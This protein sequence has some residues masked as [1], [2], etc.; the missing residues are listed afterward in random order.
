ME[1]GVDGTTAAAHAG[2]SIARVI[3]TAGGLNKVMDDATAGYSDRYPFRILDQGSVIGA[4]DFTWV[5]GGTSTI[6]DTDL[7]RLVSTPETTS[8]VNVRMAVRSVPSSTPYQV[9]GHFQ[10][11]PGY[12]AS[13]ISMFGLCLR[14]SSSYKI[15]ANVLR[16]TETVRFRRYTSA[17]SFDAD[18]YSLSFKTNDLWVR[19]KVDA[20]TVYGYCSG[21]GVT[22][23]SMSSQAYTSWMTTGP[24]QV[25][26]CFDP[27]A[28]KTGA[29]FHINSFVVEGL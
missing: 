20:T 26:V 4:S 12:D 25:G 1:R 19:M 17:T 7:D 10:F 23:F 29:L 11:G 14:E 5:N 16:V 21:D 8:S 28:I 6:S 24:D 15:Y 9:T 2:G 27:R 22:W 13:G 18:I 3:L